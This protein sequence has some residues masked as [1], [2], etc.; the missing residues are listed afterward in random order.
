MA[1]IAATLFSRVLNL[2]QKAT[3]TLHES[4]R[5][6]AL[7]KTPRDL[8]PI[9]NALKE[10]G[11]S[12]EQF[13]VVTEL[14]LR[15][16]ALKKEAARYDDLLARLL[17]AE[18]ATASHVAETEAVI[19]AREDRRVELVRIAHELR[20]ETDR[21]GLAREEL[22]RLEYIHSEAFGLTRPDL[23][24]CTPSFTGRTPMLCDPDAPVVNVPEDVFKAVASRR[25]KIYWS[26]FHI[27]R[28]EYNN[29]VT[30]WSA[31]GKK[32]F[33][34]RILSSPPDALQEPSWKHHYLEAD[35]DRRSEIDRL[36]NHPDILDRGFKPFGEYQFSL[37]PAE[38]L[39]A[40]P[41][42]EEPAESVKA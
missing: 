4:A 18:A 34:G 41:R 30:A 33:F 15:R 13:E 40:L 9:E 36:A 20:A 3:N 5:A 38:I 17:K 37:Q 12:A 8:G 10:S 27:L 35:S 7:G 11:M 31:K 32:N 42:N 39:P 19:K 2:K 28:D 23:D 1:G 14:H 25:E 21:T 6:I 29:A 16:E 22:Q 26:L 24:R